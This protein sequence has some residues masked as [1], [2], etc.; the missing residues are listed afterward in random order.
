MKEFLLN[1]SRKKFVRNV[2]IMA[3]GTAAAQGVMMLFSPFITRLYGPEIFGVQGVF[4][5][6]AGIFAPIAALAYPIAI[7]LPRKREDAKGLAKL[8]LYI[9]V[10]ITLLVGLILFLFNQPL[11]KWLQMEEITSYLYLI[12]IF[13]FFSGFLQ[14]I[15]QWLIRENKFSVS[16]KST[17]LHALLLQGSKVGVGFFYPL[18]SVLVIL[19]TAGQALKAVLMIGMS[20]DTWKQTDDNKNNPSLKVLAKEHRDFPIYRAPQVFIDGFSQSLPVI[21]LASFFGPAASGFFT[22]CKTVL[23]I[24][25][26]LIGKAV[27]DVF[28]PRITEAANNKERL[29]DLIKKAT[30]ALG[31]IGIIPFGL[32]ILLGPWLFELVF[33]ADWERAG[34]YARWLA[35]WGY[36][37]FINQPSVKSLAVLGVQSFHLGYTIITFV[38]RMAALTVGYYVFNNDLV[39]VALFGVTGAIL[40]FLL[41]FITLRISKRFDSQFP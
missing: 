40:N 28:Y 14:V 17:F 26:K 34:E 19:S 41:I 23:A 8:S 1:L 35:L 21:L 3:T 20:K 25:T 30:L 5:S 12:P 31:G 32:I 6:I 37:K 22:I 36:F 39:A 27:G 7:V 2:F 29:S 11:V 15:E 13:I 33:G 16:A 18:A 38:V 24:P 10:V 4:M 9:T